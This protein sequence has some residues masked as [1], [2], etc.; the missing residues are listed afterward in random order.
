MSI[1]GV[2]PNST[3]RRATPRAATS[4]SFW[5]GVA[6]VVDIAPYRGDGTTV[7]TGVAGRMADREALREDLA[8]VRTTRAR[9]A[10]QTHRRALDS[11]EA[12]RAEERSTF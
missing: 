8:R 5:R 1:K 9:V 10:K 7:L 11:V 6:S 4:P 2:S 3:P 12:R